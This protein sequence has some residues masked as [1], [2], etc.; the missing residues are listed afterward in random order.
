MDVKNAEVELNYE[1]KYNCK[2]LF[3]EYKKEMKLNRFKEL[4]EK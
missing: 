3:E 4:L 1:P 2:A